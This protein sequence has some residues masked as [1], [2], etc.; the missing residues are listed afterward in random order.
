VGT[1]HPLNRPQTYDDVAQFY[2]PET[3]H[4][5]GHMSDICRKIITSGIKSGH[6]LPSLS[7][8]QLHRKKHK[9][10]GAWPNRP[11]RIGSWGHAAQCTRRPPLS[12][13]R[14]PTVGV[15]G[16]GGAMPWPA[17]RHIRDRAR[18]SSSRH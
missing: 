2:C 4:A 6:L 14:E 16:A 8:L 11:H 9:A 15:A 17:G 13:N 5:E 1:K 10:Q 12:G 3:C 18:A 7:N